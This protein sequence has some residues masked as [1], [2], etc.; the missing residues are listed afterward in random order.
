MERGVPFDFIEEDPWKKSERLLQLN[1]LGKVPVLV[2]DDGQVFFDSLA[3]IQVLDELSPQSGRMLPMSGQA[4]WEVMK[5]HALAQGII[6]AVVNRLLETRRPD[7][8]QME[9]HMKREEARFDRTLAYVATNLDVVPVGDADR[10]GFVELM[11]GVALR[12]ADFR[13]PHAWRESHPRLADLV[14]RLAVRP[15]FLQTDPP[16]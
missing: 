9:G 13:Y 16:G 4:Y 14:E 5:W 7:A 1:P 12:Y 2:L 8:F 10:P 11:L 15:S 3:I 6:D